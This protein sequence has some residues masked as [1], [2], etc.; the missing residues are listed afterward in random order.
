MQDYLGELSHFGRC[1]SVRRVN[2]GFEKDR[3]QAHT[4]GVWSN[5]TLVHWHSRKQAL[6]TQCLGDAVL[7]RYSVN[8]NS[9]AMLVAKLLKMGQE[10]VLEPDVA[11][12]FSGVGCGRFRIASIHG[13]WTRFQ[14]KSTNLDRALCKVRSGWW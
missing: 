8:T 6:Q 13:L 10:T 7:F 12:N 2:L 1:S 5:A 3:K 11:F 4:T 14:E 9:T